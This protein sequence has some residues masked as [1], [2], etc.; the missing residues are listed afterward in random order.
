MTWSCIEKHSDILIGHFPIRLYANFHYISNAS[1]GNNTQ[2]IDAGN[3]Q[4]IDPT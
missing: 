4:L 1:G 3:Q 2:S